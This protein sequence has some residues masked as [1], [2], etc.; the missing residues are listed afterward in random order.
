MA[1]LV[2]GSGVGGVRRGADDAI[3]R[4]DP[5]SGPDPDAVDPDDAG[6]DDAGSDDEDRHATLDGPNGDTEGGS[7]DDDRARSANG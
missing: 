2:V 1:V 4:P 7:G 6:S 3:A 5:Q